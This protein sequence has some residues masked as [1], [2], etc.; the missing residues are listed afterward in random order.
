M[1]PARDFSPAWS[2]DGRWIAFLRGEVPGRSE[3][4][5]VPPLGGAERR[6]GEIHIRQSYVFPPYLSWFPDSSALVIV[7]SPAPGQT[8]GLFV[9]SIETGEKHAL[10]TPPAGNPDHNTSCVARRAH[11]GVQE[12][13]NALRSSR[14]GKTSKRPQSPGSLQARVARPHSPTWTPDGKEIVYSRNRSLWRLDPSGERPP[15]P[16]P[17]RWAG[18]DHARAF[19][20]HPRQADPIGLRSKDC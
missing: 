18:R 3:L 10:T 6:V 13:C 2:P 1:H 7:H 4:M 16:T 17:I 20:F 9:I 19:P 12:R 15:A 5:L 14:W 11:S 8:E